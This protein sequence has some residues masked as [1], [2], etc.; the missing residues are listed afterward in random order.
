MKAADALGSFPDP[1]VAEWI[2]HLLQN[3]ADAGVKREAHL[4][5]EQIQKAN[6]RRVVNKNPPGL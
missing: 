5:L 4:A 1:R 6:G 3:D 2:T